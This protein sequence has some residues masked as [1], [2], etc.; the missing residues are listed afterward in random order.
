[1]VLR[2]NWRSVPLAPKYF[3]L[4]LAGWLALHSRLAWTGWLALSLALAFS[5]VCAVVWMNNDQ[6]V[7]WLLS[8]GLVAEANTNTLPGDINQGAIGAG[9]AGLVATLLIVLRAVFGIFPWSPL[10]AAAGHVGK[11]LRP[12]MGPILN[13]AFRVLLNISAVGASLLRYLRRAALAAFRPL[14]SAASTTGSLAVRLLTLLLVWVQTV[15]V[16][17]VRRTGMILGLVLRMGWTAI[18]MPFAQAGKGIKFA[19]VQLRRT[20]SLAVRASQLAFAAVIRPIEL[21]FVT[22]AKA[23]GFA[24][25]RIRNGVIIVGGS[26]GRAARA[27]G[28][29]FGALLG[30]LERATGTVLGF[31][32][33]AFFLA[34]GL[35]WMAGWDPLHW[36]WRRLVSALAVAWLRIAA[37]LGGMGRTLMASVRLARLAASTAVRPMHHCVLAAAAATK[38][39]V[40]L[41]A[42]GIATALASVKASVSAVAQPL[43]Y[44]ARAAVTAAVGWAG[45]MAKRLATA[46]VPIGLGATLVAGYIHTAVTPLMGYLQRAASLVS[47]A[48]S[49][50]L[51]L[52]TALVLSL[53]WSVF[54]VARHLWFGASTAALLVRW[55]GRGAWAGGLQVLRVF[56]LVPWFVARMIW[57]GIG[58]APNAGRAALWLATNRKEAFLMTNFNLTRQGVISLIATL[59]VLGLAGTFAGWALWPTA[60]EP[61]VEVQH[62]ST[63]HLMREGEE[64]RLLPVMAEEFN[65]AEH[66]T[67]SGTRIVVKVHNV[68]SELIAEY[69]VPRVNSGRRI[70]LTGLSDGYVKPGYLDPTI[71]TPSS[72]HWLVSVNHEVS[73]DLVDLDSAQSIVRP[74]IGIVTFEEMARCLGW[75]EKE[76]GYADI[77]ALRADPLGW[78]KYDCARPQW[79]Q[80][81][82]VAFTDPTTSSTGRSLLLGLYFVAAGVPPE[83]LTTADVNDPAVASYVKDFQGLID[84]Y[85]I[86]TTVLNTKIHQGPAYGHFFIMPEDN[87]IHLYEGTE[88]AFING[89]KVQAPPIAPGSMVMIYPKEGAMPRNNCACIIK[90]DWVAPEQME[91]AQVWI[92]FLLDDQQQRSFMAAGFRP[93]GDISLTDPSSKINGQFGLD[94]AKPTATLNPSRIDPAVAA[95]IDRNWQ[96]VKRPG[97]VTFVVDT[98]GSM[99]GAKIDQAK[100]GLVLALENMAK[101]NRVGLLGFNET[102]H[103]RVPVAPMAENGF[104]IAAEV[105][106]MRARG[107]T[108]LYDAIK[109]GIEMTDA[110]NGPEDAIRAVVVLTDGRANRGEV[111]LH[112]LIR[113]STRDERPVQYFRGFADDESAVVAGGGKIEKTSLIGD[114]LAIAS[115]NPIQIFFIGIGGDADLDVGRML[116]E[117]TGAEFQG[118]T[119]KDLASVLEEFSKYF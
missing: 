80:R 56:P 90:A 92:D 46:I 40:S 27:G 22:L 63:G 14:Q 84:H 110:A 38:V 26:L 30:R 50:L 3:R 89:V 98:S 112:D 17:P 53:G 32:S 104:K 4:A 43:G 60:P 19:L 113:M 25:D 48:V 9:I 58:S 70:D 87:L 66:R 68:P 106:E 57:T 1:M 101:N 5:A 29:V 10:L 24:L 28:Y 67:E 91:A 111:E 54:L 42:S 20:A 23:A 114:E 13:E 105:K 88:R 47:Q 94:P 44:L 107:E 49:P 34:L 61:T 65:R 117:A 6:T 116:A 96:L 52:M 45:F 12:V 119:E 82:L 2:D 102:I 109:A 62:W 21:L 93:G 55:L 39:T 69:L 33:G 59:W 95:E 103:T 74:V 18:S 77:L 41:A 37:A 73:R 75:P 36:V 85:L 78:A 15:I 97:I 108:A 31:L 71:V 99:M 86:G 76:L 7:A 11:A 79:G 51:W 16:T 64:I 118:V 8:Q 81:P 72:A 83:E 35:L 115:R 100:D